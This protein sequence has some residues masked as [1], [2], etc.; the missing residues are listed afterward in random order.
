MADV[1]VTCIRKS[2]SPIGHGQITHIGNPAAGWMWSRE[3]VIESIGANTNSFYVFDRATM[4]RAYI[5][6]VVSPG[7]P[8]SLSTYADGKWT[9]HLMHLPQ[10]G[11]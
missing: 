1:E 8:P 11:T 5:G 10:C 9:E 6:V 4:K 3:Q 2:L 7:V